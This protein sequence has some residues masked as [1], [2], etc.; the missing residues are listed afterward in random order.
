[1][2]F[3]NT[4]LDSGYTTLRDVPAV[5]VDQCTVGEVSLELHE[6]STGQAVDLTQWGIESS[7]S[8]SSSG[9]FTGVRV[10]LKELPTDANVWYETEAI[11]T[12]ASQGKIK[13]PYTAHDVRRSGIF[14]AEAQVWQDGTMRRVYPFFFGVNPSLAGQPSHSRQTLSIAEI[15]MTLRDVDP[16]GNKLLDELEYSQQ[17]IMLAIRRCINY[18]NEVPPPIGTY[19]PTNFPFPYHLSIGVA[20]ILYSMAVHEKLRNDLPYS[21]GGV[22]VQDTVKW[23]QYREMQDRLHKEWADWVKAKKYQMNIEGGFMSLGSGYGY[24]RYYR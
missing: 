9:E 19:K 18:W 17:E 11:V 4:C 1:M 24:D 12:D 7:S 23:V 2:A 20:S 21:A 13:I 8:S 15:R 22:T 16:H 10:V 3:S 14:T 6:P 5:E